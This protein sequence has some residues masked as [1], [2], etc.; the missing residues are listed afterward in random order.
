MYGLAVRRVTWAVIRLTRGENCLV[1][2][3]LSLLGGVSVSDHGA[4]TPQVFAA[5]ACMAAIL[6]FGNCVNDIVDLPLDRVAKPRRPLPSQRVTVR[7]AVWLAVLLAVVAMLLGVVLGG[8]FVALVMVMLAASWLYSY[9]LKS[10]V[11]VGHLVV[12]ALT[13]M[14]VVAGALASGMTN[15][16]YVYLAVSVGLMVLATEVAKAIE[17]QFEDGRHGVR[18]VAH[19]VG[20]RGQRVALVVVGL[21]YMTFT[22]AAGLAIRGMS[23]LSASLLIVPALPYVWLPIMDRTAV[24]LV[25][26]RCA[27]V[28]KMLWPVAIVGVLTLI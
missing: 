22:L 17:D 24:D 1:V 28:G 19:C 11:M 5:G 9:R 13:A 4:A 20:V 12:A 25:A 21:G 6:G 26:G 2:F 23:S 8:T 14:T 15:R 27:R 18:T 7:F 3:A 16:S 10:T